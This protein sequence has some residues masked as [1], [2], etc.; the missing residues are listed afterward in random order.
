MKMYTARFPQLQ[1]TLKKTR[2]KQQNTKNQKT[3]SHKKYIPRALYSAV[4]W[5]NYLSTYR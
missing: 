5:A 4:D 1:L 3:H 2:S